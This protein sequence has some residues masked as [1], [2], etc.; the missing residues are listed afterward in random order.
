MPREVKQAFIAF[1]VGLAVIST[2]L[3]A[4]VSAQ[5]TYFDALYF[6][7]RDKRLADTPKLA[8]AGFSL[9]ASSFTPDDAA[10]LKLCQDRK[11]E[12]VYQTNTGSLADHRKQWDAFPAVKI[13]YNVLDDADL[14]STPE[15]LKALVT[16]VQ[17]QLRPG[18]ETFASFSKSAKPEQWANITKNV[19]LQLYIYHEGGLKKW[20]WDYPKAW[21]AAHT[22]GKVYVGPYLGKNMPLFFGLYPK[23]PD[24]QPA[25]PIPWWVDSI[26]TPVQ[27]NEAQVWMAVCLECE[28][29]FYSAYSISPSIPT[30]SYR[31]TDQPRLLAGYAE[32]F[33][34][35]KEA[36]RFTKVVK[37]VQ[38][39]NG[40][41][42]GATWTLPTG[43]A[44]RV[45]IDT[46][47][48][49]PNVD[50]EI[51]RAPQKTSVVITS[52][53]PIAVETKP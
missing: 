21:K 33:R 1:F 24:G 51:T 34:Q 46:L 15:K 20:G 19:H 36:E 37:P 7:S 29:L 48:A 5:G 31:I 9:L 50:P 40:R 28:V 43:E 12:V 8:D 10:I 35:V 6:D 53:G 14:N 39:D 11:L 47:D 38:F 26:Y 27:W 22:G 42:V 4:C 17:P 23:H 16:A 13:Q 41:F 49:H 18:M 44:L 25:P 45:E 2:V 3:V 52:N 32:V 30:A